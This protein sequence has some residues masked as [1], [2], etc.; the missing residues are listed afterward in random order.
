MARVPSPA[1]WVLAQ[2]VPL[3]LVENLRV[4]TAPAADDHDDGLAFEVRQGTAPPLRIEQ[5]ERGA[6]SGLDQH[7][8]VVQ[9]RDAC[10]DG[11]GVSHSA[12]GSGVLLAHGAS[13][14]V[15]RRGV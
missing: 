10:R 5:G 15:R 6:A 13:Q 3:P 2:D 11:L 12:C 9:Q 7:T 14:G 8:M 1:A 4:D